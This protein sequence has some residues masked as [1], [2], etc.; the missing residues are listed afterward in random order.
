MGTKFFAT[1]ALLLSLMATPAMGQRNTVGTVRAKG[2]AFNRGFP[3]GA[4]WEY[5]ACGGGWSS[6]ATFLRVT[7]RNSFAP[8][9]SRNR[10]GLRLALSD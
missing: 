1:A 6:T 10:I 3:T 7:F 8:K 4:E 5:A 9:K 2:G